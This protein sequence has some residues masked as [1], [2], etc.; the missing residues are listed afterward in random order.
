MHKKSVMHVQICFFSFKISLL[1]C[2]FFFAFSLPSPS[3]LLLM[4]K[5]FRKLFMRVNKKEM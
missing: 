3:S 1:V 5:R 4:Y 2:L